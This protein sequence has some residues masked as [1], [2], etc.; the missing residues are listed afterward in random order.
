[1]SFTHE[2]KTKVTTAGRS[3]ENVRSFSADLELSMEVPV[4]GSVTDQES[5][6][7]IDISQ[8]KAFYMVSDQDLTVE[9]ND[10]TTPADTIVLVANEPYI[11]NEDSYDAFQLG[12]DVTSLFLTN[13]GATAATFNL[14]VLYDST[15]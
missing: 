13:A 2:I 9:T 15:P 3:V 14:E 8:V 10:G 4:A 7:G 12:T 5:V 6:V 1:M 11:W